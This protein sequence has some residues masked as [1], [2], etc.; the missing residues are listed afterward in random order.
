M[1]DRSWC[2]CLAAL[3]RP[4]SGLCPRC[5]KLRAAYSR[6]PVHLAKAPAVT[7]PG[8]RHRELRRHRRRESEMGLF[9]KAPPSARFRARYSAGR[10]AWMR[11]GSMAATLLEGHE[12]LEVVGESYYQP[13]LWRLLGSQHRPEVRERTVVYAMLLAADGNPHDDNAASVW[14]DGHQVGH[15]SRDVAQRV[16]RRVLASHDK[17]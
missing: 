1:A 3:I 11:E 17:H 15:L 9:S 8:I 4:C 16:R 12:N 5:G 14:I 2:S 10:P 6:R 13:D 7:Y